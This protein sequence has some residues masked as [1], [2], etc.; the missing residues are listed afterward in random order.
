MSSS[1]FTPK[2]PIEEGTDAEYSTVFVDADA[3]NSEIQGAAISTIVA[4]LRDVATDTIINGREDQDVKNVN[5]GSVDADGIFTLRLKEADTLAIDQDSPEALEEHELTLKV[6]YTD[7][8]GDPATLNH[9]I[10]YY[11]ERLHEV[12]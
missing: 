12:E 11:I 8:N 10:R 9:K 6:G 1:R 7:T 5:G 2:E 3:D 4:T